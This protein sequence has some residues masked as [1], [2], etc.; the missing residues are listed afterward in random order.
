MTTSL[1]FHPPARLL[2]GPG[3]SNVEER[4]LRAMSTQLV[5]YFDSCLL[6]VAAEIRRLLNLAFGTKNHVT[7][8]ISGTGSAGMEAALINM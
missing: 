5:G 2:L 1:T 6:E 3:P 8:P 7:L 4:V